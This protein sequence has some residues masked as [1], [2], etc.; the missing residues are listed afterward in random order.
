MAFFK[1]KPWEDDPDVEVSELSGSETSGSWESDPESGVSVESAAGAIG[2]AGTSAA[3]EYS[4]IVP[5][6]I[7]GAKIGALGGPYAPVTVPAGAAIGAYAGYKAGK[8]LQEMAEQTDFAGA[9]LAQKPEDMSE[10]LRPYGFIG[11]VIGASVPFMMTPVWAAR[12]ESY[13]PKSKVGNFINRIITTASEYPLQ[14]ATAETGM[15]ISSGVAE[16]VTESYAPG[17]T[18]KRIAAGIVGGF[19]NPIRLYFGVYNF[20]KEGVLKSIRT[21]SQSGREMVAAEQLQKL[22]Q[23]FGEDPVA[24]AKALRESSIPGLDLNLTAGQKSG[25]PALIALEHRLARE[26][27]KYGAEMEQMAKDSLF[28]IEAAIHGLR[29]TGEPG[30]LKVAAQLEQK[31]YRAIISGRLQVAER[32]SIEAAQKITRDT[33]GDRAA[34]SSQAE[35]SLNNAMDDVRTVESELWS[36]ID[37]EIVIPLS[38]DME[39]FKRYKELKSQLLPRET[40]GEIIEGTIADLSDAGQASVGDLVRLRSRLLSMAKSEMANSKP[41]EARQLGVL[42]EA[43]L[44]DLDRIAPNPEFA[45]IYNTAR[46]FSKE[47]NDVF[48][49]TFAGDVLAAKKTGAERIP[50]ELMMRRALGTAKEGGALRFRELEEA[51]GFIKSQSGKVDIPEEILAGSEQDMAAMVDAQDRILR[52][53]ATDMVDMKT[54]KV[55]VARLEKYIRDNEEIFTRFPEIKKDLLELASSADNLKRIQKSMDVAQKAIDQK[56]IFSKAV[57]YENGA[58]AVN[59]ALS[60]NSPVKDMM[61]LSRLAHK[62]KSIE[63][64]KASIWD[65]VTRKATDTQGNFSFNRFRHSLFEPIAPGQ[66]SVA[67]IMETEGVMSKADIDKVDKLL[68]EADQIEAAL[69]KGQSIDQILDQHGAVA[70]FVMRVTGARFAAVSPTGG[71][72]ALIVGGAGSRLARY[73]LGKVPNIRTKELLEKSRDP[74][75]AAMLLEKPVTKEGWRKL[76]I[77]LHAYLIAAGLSESEE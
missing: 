50:P 33:P 36:K 16:G 65:D 68:I 39:I 44:D 32:E 22:V 7:A 57:K 35:K 66:P 70:D 67:R 38:E 23:E 26:S 5:G 34:L 69:I 9:P 54:G 14:F 75:F 21:V 4:P 17:E 30:A 76:G 49:R 64:L 11:D 18:G 55:N 28:N 10:E 37:K 45:E 58:D 60:G 25:S 63:G 72:H 2:Q 46:T 62:T 19:L 61:A 59:N 48:T 41:F 27:S 12:T 8:G 51:T 52:L 47:L 15:A 13:L 71:A 73:I 53:A 77:Q 42:A 6:M 56:A 31:Y 74:A 40:M 24:L 3:L 1:K 29:G 43:I 20:A